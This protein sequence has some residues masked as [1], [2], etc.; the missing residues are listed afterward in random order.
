MLLEETK[1]HRLSL[2][3]QSGAIDEYRA[4]VQQAEGMKISQLVADSNWELYGRYI[5]REKE[6]H[7]ESAKIQQAALLNI[8]S[9]LDGPDLLK[10]R[11]RL[12]HNV[13]C[14]Q[15]YALA[16]SIAKTLIE[17]GVDAGAEIAKLISVDTLDKTA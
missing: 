7:E 12:A 15:A 5:E 11:L 16:L 10:C 2:L 13:A 9:P 1:A 6:R 4:K 14:V 8:D 3:M 17:R